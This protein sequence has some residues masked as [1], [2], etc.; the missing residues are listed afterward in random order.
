MEFS[1]LQWRNV[2]S[3]M[4][5]EGWRPGVIVESTESTPWSRR[6][7]GA[8][9]TEATVGSYDNYCFIQ[10]PVKTTASITFYL[11]CCQVYQIIRMLMCITS[12]WSWPLRAYHLRPQSIS[13][14]GNPMCSFFPV[15]HQEKFL[16]LCDFTVLYVFPDIVVPGDWQPS[17]NIYKKLQFRPS[18]YLPR[19]C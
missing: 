5:M 7:R 4:A 18:V 17:I 10:H 1:Q 8:E 6:Y 13:T 11:S 3:S 12:G 16:I 9:D 2:N 19:W 14:L 15:G